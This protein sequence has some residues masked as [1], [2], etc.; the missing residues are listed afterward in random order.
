MHI[1]W[2]PWL[3]RFRGHCWD[4]LSCGS[5]CHMDFICRG[6][7]GSG[8]G[9]FHFVT[10]YLMWG[11]GALT[12]LGPPHF[13]LTNY[14]T[15]PHTVTGGALTS[16][17]SVPCTLSV[18]SYSWAATALCSDQCSLPHTDQTYIRWWGAP[19][20]IITHSGAWGIHPIGEMFFSNLL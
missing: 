16:L 3:G 13:A 8:W 19:R 5:T 11:G 18:Q 6:P 4:T 17:G 12:S 1:I 2:F 10:F 9:S 15:F 20:N 14:P 7:G